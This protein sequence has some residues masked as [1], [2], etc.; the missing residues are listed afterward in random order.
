MN[1]IFPNYT[2]GTFGYVRQG[3]F[4]PRRG[5]MMYA[6]TT[7]THHQ[8]SFTQ[9]TFFPFP[10]DMLLNPSKADLQIS[11]DPA[12]RIGDGNF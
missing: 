4:D 8:D 5:D 7:H 10:H 2:T 11:F 3:L 12:R 1:E 9:T 6:G